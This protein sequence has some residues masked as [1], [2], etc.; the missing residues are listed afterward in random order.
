[1]PNRSSTGDTTRVMRTSATFFVMW[2]YTCQ[3]VSTRF[4]V[5]EEQSVLLGIDNKFYLS[6]KPG[7]VARGGLI[8]SV[9]SQVS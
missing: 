2:Y 9:G 1:M 4:S 7:V 3:N 5:A 8:I 6:T